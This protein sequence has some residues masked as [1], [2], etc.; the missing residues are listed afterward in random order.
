MFL[1][2]VHPCGLNF[3]IAGWLA[4]CIHRFF[5]R[6]R[7]TL[8]HAPREAPHLL[9]LDKGHNILFRRRAVTECA[10]DLPVASLG[11]FAGC[12]FFARN[13]EKREYRLAL[14][15]GFACQLVEMAYQQAGCK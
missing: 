6:C 9:F 1:R 12:K 15:M 2:P 8:L 5:F 13:S 4:R 11:V 10:D 7:P 3:G 14:A